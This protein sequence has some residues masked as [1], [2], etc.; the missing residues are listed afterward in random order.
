MSK[1]KDKIYNFLVRKD[2][3]V[4]YEYERYVLEHLEEHYKN[5][6]KHWII[7]GKL[8]WHYKIRKRANLLLYASYTTAQNDVPL[9]NQA[10]LPIQHL[11]SSE[12]K[13]MHRP[14]PYHFVKVLLGYDVI[15]FDVFDTLLLRPFQNPVDLFDVV[16]YRLHFPAVFTGFKQA[17][18]EAEREV[19]DEM[20]YHKGNREVNIYEIYEKLHTK[21]GID[22][23][24]GVKTELETEQDYLFANPY[25]KVV[26]DI[27]LT[28]KKTI[29]LTS[30]MYIPGN[31]MEKWLSKCGYSG[32]SHLYVSCDYQCNKINGDL[33]NRIKQDYPEKTI[34]HVGDNLK[35][36]I[37]GAKRAG[38]PA[39]HYKSVNSMGQKYRGDWMSEL[40][41]SA[42]SGLVN[43][44]I[45]NGLNEYPFFYEYG[46]IY[47]G[48]Y[49][50]G[51]CKWMEQRIIEK[52]IEKV[53]FLSRDGDIYQKALHRYCTIIEIE[54]EYVYWSRFANMKYLIEMNQ[55]A[56]ISRVIDQKIRSSLTIDL[57]SIFDSFNISINYEHLQEYGLYEDTIVDSEHRSAIE[58]YIRDHWSTICRSF[59]QEKKCMAEKL[60]AILGNAKKVAVVDVGW[61]ASGPLGFKAFV[62]QYI[63]SDCEIIAWMAGGIGKYGTGTSVLPYYLDGTVDAYLFSPL[64]NKRN[65]QIHDTEN[66]AVANNAAFEMFTQTQYPSFLGL[67]TNGGYLFDISEIE[68]YSVISQIHKGIWD[69]CDLYTETFKKDSYLM[70]ISGFDAYRPFAK[71]VF[72]KQ[73]FEKNF[74]DIV[75]SYGLSGDTKH[76]KLETIGERS[77]LYY[78]RKKGL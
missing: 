49:I 62:N 28:Q 56:F 24:Q 8:I 9:N 47:G 71:L 60:T 44:Y 63:S 55:D 58:H 64:H 18:R 21:I 33:Y 66:P 2:K 59:Q 29:V 65:A 69:F 76:Q 50:L 42:Y 23:E 52:G 37:E 3:N 16:G 70:N 74:K 26:F 1:I 14:E 77:E 6:S 36:D 17:R 13:T 46:F 75:Y 12:S 20:E 43:A 45:H 34:I 68:N 38:I 22:I 30:D 11:I 7:L 27:L 5:R 32:Y 31:I 67:D 39:K 4:Q 41:Q 73:F 19:R 35:A 57:Q 72:Q 61:T 54:S 78:R 40:I 25:M 51:F 53:I 10:S 48:I 15:S